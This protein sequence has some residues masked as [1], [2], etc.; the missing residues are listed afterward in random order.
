MKYIIPRS[1]YTI[2]GEFPVKNEYGETVLKIESSKF[3]LRSRISIRDQ[4]GIEIGHI[5]KKLLSP[6]LVY[7]IYHEQTLMAVLKRGRWLFRKRYSVTTTDKD[8]YIARGNFKHLE[9]SLYMGS[10][11][12][13]KV[14]PSLAVRSEN[15]GI[16]VEKR[17]SPYICICAV[18]VIEAIE[19][20]K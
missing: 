12:V 1:S 5:Q 6:G 15:Y 17:A 10:R 18:L 3:S 13:V 19:K 4:Y 2:S 20:A 16:E 7:E 8:R 9:F 11:R 14:D